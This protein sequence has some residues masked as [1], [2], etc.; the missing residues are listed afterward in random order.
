MWHYM[1][2]D[3]DMCTYK[4]L[5]AHTVMS[6][7]MYICTCTHVD[8]HVHCLQMYMYVRSHTYYRFFQTP[9]IRPD[10]GELDIIGLCSQLSL[11]KC[12]QY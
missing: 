4:I 9:N 8:V 11:H 1:H 3:F 6:M 10:A 12:T 2:T 7:Y 5:A